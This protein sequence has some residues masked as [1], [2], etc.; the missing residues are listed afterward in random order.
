MQKAETKE[1]NNID[2]S[3][4]T[5][6]LTVKAWHKVGVHWERGAGPAGVMGGIPSDEFTHLQRLRKLDQIIQPDK[7]ITKEIT[8]LARTLTQQKNKEG[9]IVQGEY[10]TAQGEFKGFDFA[11]MQVGYE[12]TEYWARLPIIS[13]VYSGAARFDKDT[14][15]DLGKEQATGSIVGYY[16]EVPK[17]A[18]KRKKLIDSVIGNNFPENIQYYLKQGNN[19]FGARKDGSFSYEQFCQ[20]SASELIDLSRRSGGDKAPGYYRDQTGKLHD[21]DGNIIG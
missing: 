4:T 12:F 16:L 17:D 5:A 3:N 11:N 14:G 13:K 8:H 21:R 9:R 18:A 2:F 20:C 7:G 1:W 6:Y 19:P 10:L 15:Q